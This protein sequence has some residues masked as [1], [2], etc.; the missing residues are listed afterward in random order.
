MKKTCI[1]L[2]LIAFVAVIVMP[3]ILKAET[4]GTAT[5]T[6]PGMPPRPAP[7]TIRQELRNDIQNRLENAKLNQDLRNS[8]LENRASTT[9]MMMG[10]STRPF[11]G[12]TT[13]PRMMERNASTTWSTSTMPFKG[14]EN[15]QDEKPDIRGYMNNG[16]LMIQRMFEMRKNVI[17]KELQKALNNLHNVRDR[18]E[19]RIDKVASST[20]PNT[21]TSTRN[22]TEARRLLVIADA[23]ILAA[24]NAI[25]QIKAITST[26]STATST[27]T[28]TVNLDKPRLAAI[29]AQKAI[30]DAQ[31]ALNDVVIAIAK[32][33]GLKLG[34]DGRGD[35]HPA[36]TTIPVAT[37]TNTTATA[38]ATTTP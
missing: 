12:S 15:G 31:K 29:G 36:T 10:T 18:I 30:K 19:T 1:S 24:Q 20:N 14:R 17:V 7:T 22:M 21:A 37:T 32:S 34:F 6:P 38:T 23:K 5:G 9:R 26:S 11:Y 25:D 8:K 35:G 4:D 27:A 3:T 16:K 2:V 28:S 33:M 13:P